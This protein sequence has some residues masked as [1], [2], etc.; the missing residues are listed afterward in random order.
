MRETC[1]LPPA[2]ELCMGTTGDGKVERRI[3]NNSLAISGSEREG[4]KWESVTRK[5]RVLLRNRRSKQD[6]AIKEKKKLKKK[7]SF[8]L[9]WHFF[10]PQSACGFDRFP[11]IPIKD[12]NF[13]A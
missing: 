12:P 2:D 11:I 13:S 10:G 6:R 9:R 7:A 1:Q 8:P 4:Q 5:L 3:R